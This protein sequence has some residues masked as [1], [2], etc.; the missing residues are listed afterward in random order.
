MLE[1][2]ERSFCFSKK[3]NKLLNKGRKN[4]R[5]KKIKKALVKL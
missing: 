3:K 4:K 5:G 1:R 2:T